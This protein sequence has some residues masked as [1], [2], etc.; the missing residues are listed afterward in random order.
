MSKS[1]TENSRVRSKKPKGPK[2]TA[3]TRYNATKHGLL[4]E[5][6]TELD[7]GKS[8]RELSDSLAGALHPVGPVA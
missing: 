2:N 3:I 6:I 1:K 8:F 5:G 4:A 7:D